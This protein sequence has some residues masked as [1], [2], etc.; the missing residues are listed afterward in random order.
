VLVS[1]AGGKLQPEAEPATDWG[2]HVVRVLDVI[3][4][5][6]RSLRK[7]QLID[8][9]DS[10]IRKGTYWGIRTDIAEYELPDALPCPYERTLE[11]AEVPTRLDRM[12][13]RLQEQLINWGY[14][15]CDAALR[16]HVAPDLKAGAFPCPESTV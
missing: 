8:S 11:L 14:A 9:F 3:D 2:R 16:R 1:D 5:Q 15:V 7:R 10:G 6:V 12:P 13:S 4:N